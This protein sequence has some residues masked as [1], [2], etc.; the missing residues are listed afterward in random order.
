MHI[1]ERCYRGLDRDWTGGVS[2]RGRRRLDCDLESGGHGGIVFAHTAQGKGLSR[3]RLDLTEVLFLERVGKRLS[4]SRL[5]SVLIRSAYRLVRMR[6]SPY[7]DLCERAGGYRCLGWSFILGIFGRGGRE[8]GT[9]NALFVSH[10]SFY[11][12]P[13]LRCL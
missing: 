5:S 7:A 10:P 11:P 6:D 2:L 12:R 3:S 9:R 1:L 13:T 8:R 4:R